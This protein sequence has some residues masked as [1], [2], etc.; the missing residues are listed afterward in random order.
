M[1]NYKGFYGGATLLNKIGIINQVPIKAEII[2]TREISYDNKKYNLKHLYYV[3]D[4]ELYYY[5]MLL[6]ILKT[7]EEGKGLALENNY[8]EIIDSFII[9][10]DIID[11]TLSGYLDNIKEKEI[12]IRYQKYYKKAREVIFNVKKV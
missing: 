3:N 8:Q 9:E 10:N 1:D 4:Q 2:T 12:N 11:I 5:L 7:V 6:E